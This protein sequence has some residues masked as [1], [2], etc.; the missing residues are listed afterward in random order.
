MTGSSPQPILEIQDLEVAFPDTRGHLQPVIGGISI[1]VRPGERVGLVGE[2][3]SGKSLT[4]L[5]ALGLLPSSASITGGLVRVEGAD[6]STASP[7]ELN[8]LRGGV[9]G[10][11]FQEPAAAFNPVF[12]IGSQIRETLRAH[13]KIS[14]AA[15][16]RECVGLLAKAGLEDPENIS[17]AYPHQLSGGQLQRALIATALAARPRLLIADEPT[18]ALDLRTQAAILD[19]LIEIT[20]AEG[21]GLMLISHDLAVVESIVHRVVVMFAGAVV[22]QGPVA[23]VLTAPRHPYTRTLREAAHRH[24]TPPTDRPAPIPHGARATGC[25]FAGRCGFARDS[26]HA[27]PPALEEIAPG[28]WC[29][30]PFSHPEHSDGV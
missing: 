23:G 27:T 8:T 6:L 18:T 25:A 21:L 9:I 7:R 22:E 28:H 2:S 3:G 29:R 19:L 16:Q 11:V 20:D 4:A 14:R 13:R 1:T 12:T 17:A 24:L 30:C 15:A 10:F 26:C 5:S